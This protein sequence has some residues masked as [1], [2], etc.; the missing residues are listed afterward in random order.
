MAKS[1]QQLKMADAQRESTAQ[2]SY[3]AYF[4]D[5]GKQRPFSETINR[6]IAEVSAM[7]S[8]INN[9][10]IFLENLEKIESAG[11][12]SIWKFKNRIG[13]GSFDLPMNSSFSEN[14]FKFEAKDE[15]GFPFSLRINLVPAQANRG[16]IVRMRCEYDTTAGRL[17]GMVEKLLGK[18]AMT[19]TKLTAQRFKA[20]CETGSVPTIQGQSSGREED[21]SND[22]KH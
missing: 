17:A 10:P 15:G 3:E 12:T 4:Q 11:V 21:Q 16:T 8:E 22:S 5:D 13:E 14:E 6:P 9:F 20:L 18:D 7:L 2:R 1:E 19:L